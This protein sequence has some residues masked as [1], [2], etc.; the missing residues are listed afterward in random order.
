MMPLSPTELAIWVGVAFTAWLPLIAL[1]R[2][3]G[4]PAATLVAAPL[5]WI[6]ARAL[7]S[8]VP[9]VIHWAEHVVTRI[10]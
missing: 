4:V 10:G 8:T 3:L 1:L 2:R 5:S 6:L 9:Q 7:M